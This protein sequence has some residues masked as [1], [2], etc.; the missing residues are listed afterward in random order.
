[1]GA[2]PFPANNGTDW[3]KYTPI[4]KGATVSITTGGTFETMLSVSGKGFLTRAVLVSPDGSATGQIR[5]TVDGVVKVLN[6][7]PVS[8]GGMCG[9]EQINSST[10]TTG[11]YMAHR[12]PGLGRSIV[13]ANNTVAEYPTISGVE[14]IIYI[15]MPIF[16][17]TSLLIEATSSISGSQIRYEYQGGVA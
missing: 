15:S 3:G 10:A 16:F 2:T 12:V 7:A 14:N 1:M 6:Q 8:T 4:G 5:V 11:S 9:V 13:S 17:D